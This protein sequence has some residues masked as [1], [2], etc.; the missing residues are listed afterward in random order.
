MARSIPKTRRKLVLFCGGRSQGRFGRV[1]ERAK[2]R[3]ERS[4]RLFRR[5]E[6]DLCGKGLPTIG[7]GAPAGWY[8]GPALFEPGCQLDGAFRRGAKPVVRVLRNFR[9]RETLE[10]GR[11]V[12]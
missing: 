10:Q 2:L 6:Q 11:G 4:T 5:A 12:S 9:R 7:I 1:C 8:W 3:F